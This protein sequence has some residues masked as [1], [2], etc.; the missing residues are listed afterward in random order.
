ML[1]QAH[2]AFWGPEPGCWGGRMAMH[3]GPNAQHGPIG[4]P[5]L[6]HTC[7]RVHGSRLL[8]LLKST[9][10]GPSGSP[11]SNSAG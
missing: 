2:L 1:T 9:S 6:G 5:E 4:N 3:V 11:G 7:I 8:V 10:P